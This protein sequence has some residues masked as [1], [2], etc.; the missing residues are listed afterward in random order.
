MIDTHGLWGASAP[1]APATLPLT[2][3]VRVDVAV[4]GG[5]YTGLSAALHLAESGAAVAV[6]EGAEVGSGGSGR[7]VGLVNAGMWTMPDDLPGVLGQR[8]G[9]RLLECLGNGPRLVFDIVAR[10]RLD[11]E[12]RND[13][14]LH[15]AAGRGGLAE[16]EKRAE[17]WQRRG[18]PVRLLTAD[19]AARRIGTGVYAG[20]LL[21]ERAGTIQ[22]L[23]YARGLAR[24]ALEA[25]ARVHTHSRVIACD[26]ADQRWRLSTA[27]GGTVEAD[28]VIVATNAY[29]DSPWPQVRSEIVHLPY[30]NFATVP[31]SPAQREAV[32]PGG[33]GCWDTRSVLTSFRMDRAGRLVL[34]SVGALRGTGRAIHGGWARRTLQRLFP[35]LAEVPFEHSWFGW[36]GLTDNNLPR[37]H[38][39]GPRLVGFSGYNGRGIGPGTVFGRLL[40]D[41]VLGRLA[42][43]DLPLPLTDARPHGF[44][45]AHEAL[46]EHGSQAVHLLAS[47]I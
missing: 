1:Q 41:H 6:L 11:C 24:A 37:F 16:L 18:A 27:S 2:E 46:Y 34:G 26:R 20:A 8:Y 23:A 12:A 21:D 29:T 13:G 42:E 33:E 45:R 36:I 3:T 32:L 43:D 7:N 19:E 31:L 28:W 5:G 44:R 38:R 15:C 30:F 10:H 9:D 17:Q 25:G 22:P 40:C 47:R 35:A 39:F 14:T 4:V